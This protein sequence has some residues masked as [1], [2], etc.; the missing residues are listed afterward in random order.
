MFVLGNRTASLLSFTVILWLLLSL[1]KKMPV[2]SSIVPRAQTGPEIIL[3]K[4]LSHS[5]L[6]RYIL[7]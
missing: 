7:F 5:F 1:R 2:I 3:N 6:F 4:H